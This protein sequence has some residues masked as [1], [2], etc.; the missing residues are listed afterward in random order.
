MEKKLR[1][2]PKAEEELNQ[3]YDWHNE[4]RSGSG[5]DFLDSVKN[6]IDQISENPESRSADSD[7]VRWASVAKFPYHI[8]YLFRA[9]IVW[10]LAI[11]HNSRKPE[12]WKERVNDLD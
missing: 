2:H 5:D 6:K 4:N 9:P 3:S 11:W 8:Y 10:I 1:L 12:G 7:G